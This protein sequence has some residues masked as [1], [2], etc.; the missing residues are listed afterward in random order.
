MGDGHFCDRIADRSND[1]EVAVRNVKYII[2]KLFNEKLCELLYIQERCRIMNQNCRCI[3]VY[4][5]TD[6]DNVSICFDFDKRV[7][8]NKISMRLRTYIKDHPYQDDSL[9][10]TKIPFYRFDFKHETNQLSLL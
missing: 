10:N 6:T 2:T 7:P 8:E 5:I 3:V 9:W 1:V 4:H